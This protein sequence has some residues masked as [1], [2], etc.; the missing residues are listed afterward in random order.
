M[1]V[2]GYN[3]QHHDNRQYYCTIYLKVAKRVIL[4]CSHHKKEMNIIGLVNVLANTVVAIMCACSVAQLCPTLCDSMDCNPPDSSIHGIFQV[5]I[6]KWVA[7][8][9]SKGSS[10]TGIKPTSPALAGGLYT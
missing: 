5:R 6:L 10:H 7:I 8:S 9:Y 3:A 1:N 4:K 2:W